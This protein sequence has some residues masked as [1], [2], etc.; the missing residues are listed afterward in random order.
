MSQVPRPSGFGTY[1]V[2]ARRQSHAERG[3]DGHRQRQADAADEDPHEV[4]GNVF[5]GHEVEGAAAVELHGHE[6][7]EGDA[8]VGEP[9]A[10][11]EGLPP[12]CSTPVRSI[13]ILPPQARECLRKQSDPDHGQPCA[14]PGSTVQRH[15]VSRRRDA[16]GSTMMQP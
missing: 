11:V 2:R 13:A 7:D 8:E 16:T 3:G 6:Q 10:E 5:T 12:V 1:R 9:L 15:A 14:P 4:F